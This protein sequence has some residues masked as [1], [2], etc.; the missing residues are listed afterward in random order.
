V[1]CVHRVT[2]LSRPRDWLALER[3]VAH[4]QSLGQGV[5]PGPTFAASR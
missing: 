1:F 5:G 3:G 4:P 2:Y